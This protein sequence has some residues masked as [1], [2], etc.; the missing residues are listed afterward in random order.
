M[1]EP[2]PK[3]SFGQHFLTD[4]RAALDIAEAATPTPGGTVLEIGPGKGVLTR[5]LL[6]RAARV[7]AIE[8]DRELIPYLQGVFPEEIAAGRL[9]LVEDDAASADWEAALAQGPL[10]RMIAGNIPYN[11]TGKLLEIAVHRAA[12]VDGVVFLMQKE[13]AD[14]LA[15][16]PDSSDYGALSVFTQAAF[17]VE[18]VRLVRRGAFFPPPKVESTVVRLHTRRPPLAEETPVF[19]ELVKRAFLQRRKTLRNAWKGIF[20]WSVEALAARAASAGI[21]LDARGETLGVLDFDRM[22]RGV[23]AAPPDHGSSL[24]DPA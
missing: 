19:R 14:R 11:I 8:R 4:Q 13:V 16:P 10:P 24:S 1:N 20:G 7:V 5:Y 2:R 9:C 21:S 12:I 6:A 3:K 23:E 22:A 15:A 17:S 18:R